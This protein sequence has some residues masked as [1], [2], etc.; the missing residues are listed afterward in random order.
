[1]HVPV[2]FFNIHSTRGYLQ[3]EILIFNNILTI[4]SNKNTMHDIHKFEKKM[5]LTHLNSIE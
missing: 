1:M 5:Q 4:N 2:Y 3:K